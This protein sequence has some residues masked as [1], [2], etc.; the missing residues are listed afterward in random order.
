VER[1]FQEAC[2]KI[3]QIRTII[4]ALTPTN[5]R[6]TTPTTRLG[7]ASYGG[8]H[9]QGQGGVPSPTNTA[10]NGLSSPAS[11]LTINSLS[12]SHHTTT[13]LPHRQHS[14]SS[15]S[16]HHVPVNKTNSDLSSLDG[17]SS[18]LT[19]YSSS[20]VHQQG[21]ITMLGSDNN[22]MKF[23][24]H[25]RSQSA[26]PP[27]SLENLQLLSL[28]P[29]VK[30]KELPTPSSTPTTSRKSRRRSNLFIPSSSKKEEKLKNSELGSGRSIPLK[31]GYLY[32]RSSK[33]LNKEW[34]KKYVTLCDDG[35]LTYHASLHDY[36]DNVHGKEI[37]L[38]Y[39]TVKVP[40]QKPRGSKSIITNSAL[41]KNGS[42]TNNNINNNITNSI[43]ESLG[44]LSLLSKDKR[45]SSEKVTLTAYDNLKEHGKANSQGSGDESGIHS[46]SNSQNLGS[47]SN[48]KIDSQT[49]NLKKRHR[50]MKS[51]G[52]KSNDL[53]GENLFWKFREL[54]LKNKNSINF[55]FCRSRW[56]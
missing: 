38:Q 48:S 39:V 24:Q 37:S 52:V 13:T 6:P 34:K 20:N 25:E 44:V 19:K 17:S 10:T 33:S 1:V 26:A 15:S 46:N 29:P 47:D 22:N 7:V 18:P 40:G 53:E 32:K 16:S 49:P 35:R 9:G 4:P 8:Y 14:L 51:S 45:A 55:I 41:T 42:A 3:V 43:T 36:M 2:Q 28:A 23:I 21:L 12:P 56:I 30:E 5:S 31:Q 11:A 27:S 54:T 50:R